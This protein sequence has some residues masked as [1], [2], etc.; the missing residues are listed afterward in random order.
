MAIHD[1]KP[2]A[3]AEEEAFEHAPDADKL[4][5]EHAERIM[6]ESLRGMNEGQL[7][8]LEKSIVR[9]IDMVIL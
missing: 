1:E 7:A 8:V 9:K 2:K 3:A 5:T 6:P 4:H